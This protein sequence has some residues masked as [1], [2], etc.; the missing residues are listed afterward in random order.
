[1]KNILFVA[2]ESSPFVKTGGLGEVVGSLPK[3]LR[4]RK[5]DVRV[6]LP[7]YGTIA[8][9]FRENMT[10]SRALT[11]PV[12]WRQQYCGIERLEYE[13]VPFYFIDNEFYFKR[14]G[15]YGYFDEAERFSFFS[16]ACLEAL[17]YLDFKPHVLHCHDWQTALVPLFLNVFYKNRSFY[18]KIKTVFTIHNLKYQGVFT[19]WILN[20]LLGLGDGFFTPDKLE[21]YGKVNLMKAGIIYCDRLT[22]VSPTY[23]LEVKYPFYGEGMDGLLRMHENKLR[24]ILNGLDY[25]DYNPETDPRLYVNY[26]NSLA[27]KGKN[28]LR[29]QEDLDLPVQKDVPLLGMVTR[30]TPQKGLDLLIHI[31]DE[32]LEQEVQMVILGAGEQ[33]YERRL[34]EAAWRHGRKLRVTLGFND[35]LARKIYAASDLFLMPSLFEPCGLSQMIALRYGTLPV[36][37]ET[38]GLKDTVR[39]YN[40][41]SG[42]G[43]GFSFSNYNAHDFLYTVKRAL[44][45]YNNDKTTW[46][47]IAGNAFESDYSWD[48]SARLY[49]ALYDELG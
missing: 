10:H 7:K 13:G 45:F 46:A 15:I 43:N 16:R 32:L 6:L 30:L 47:K 48:N 14:D 29:L 33:H 20:N 49:Q 18:R 37:R 1:M 26:K 21:Y 17:P 41:A 22:T 8:H 2:S 3:A 23:A 39:S 4:K 44:G 31:L 42:E 27:E 36:V 40:E 24:G 11:V 28:K 25:E 5:L 19:H 38:G 35:D 34:S 12:T 9:R